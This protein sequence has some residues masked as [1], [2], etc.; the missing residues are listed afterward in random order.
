MPC[1]NVKKRCLLLLALQCILLET[2]CHRK[3]RIKLLTKTAEDIGECQ[4]MFR[5]TADSF[6]GPSRR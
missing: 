1:K 4:V 3:Q 5:V 2:H 6:N